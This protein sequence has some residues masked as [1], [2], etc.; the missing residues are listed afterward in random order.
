MTKDQF[1]MDGKALVDPIDRAAR[2]LTIKSALQSCLEELD[3][4]ALW[5]TGAHVTMALASIETEWTGDTR[6]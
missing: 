3:K 2:T 1:L 4:L 5:R 6:A